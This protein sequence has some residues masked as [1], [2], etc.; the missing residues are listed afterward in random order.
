MKVKKKCGYCNGT[1]QQ[2]QWLTETKVEITDC[3]KC[4]GRGVRNTEII[5]N[6]KVSKERVLD[7]PLMA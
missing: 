4:N 2:R 3:E 1:G 6:R 7:E 5:D